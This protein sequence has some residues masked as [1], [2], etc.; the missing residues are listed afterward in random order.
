MRRSRLPLPKLY[1]L[2]QTYLKDST[3]PSSRQRGR[4]RTYSD[5]LILALW[6]YQTLWRA[7]YREV[8]EEARRSGLPTPALSTY[9]YR[10]SRLPLPLFQ[11][12]L[13]QVGWVLAQ[14]RPGTW[15]FLLVDGTGFGFQD[16]Y[17]L[18]WRRGE[19]L[20][21][22]RSHVRLVI[23]ALVDARGRGIL[24][25]AA[26]GPPYA[27]EIE[28]L[29]QILGS[30]DTLPPLPV[31]GDR[32]YDAV[33]LLERLRQLGAQPAL[34]MKG[35][36][37]YR[38]R[39]PLRQASQKGWQRWGRY[40]YRVEGFFG[41]MKLKMGSAFPLLRED[42]AM[43]RAL[44]VAVLYNLYRLVL[45]LRLVWPLSWAKIFVCFL[46]FRTAPDLTCI[47]LFSKGK[48]ANVGRKVFA[49]IKARNNNIRAGVFA[50][51]L[52]I[53]IQNLPSIGFCVALRSDLCGSSGSAKRRVVRDLSIRLSL[54]RL[55]SWGDRSPMPVRSLH[56]G[57]RSH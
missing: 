45:L 7:S 22:V 53:S 4:P 20:R 39:H 40:R 23:L 3:F 43:R 6:L 8:L 18:S 25:G 48:T 28:L 14:Q 26:A 55:C 30:L 52:I 50:P 33:D 32:G 1:N 11:R 54:H 21:Q 19:S 29:R 10:V 34:H 12:L 35:T 57:Q 24:L 13:T 51:A 9:H 47:F 38:V 27:S 46:I 49:A 44:A 31:V 15:R 42:L 41:L 17:A 37:R 2:V 56:R 5:A 36:W 16:R